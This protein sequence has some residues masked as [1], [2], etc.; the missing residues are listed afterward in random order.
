MLLALLACA[1]GFR[2]S[3]PPETIWDPEE[4]DQ[5]RLEVIEAYIES[6]NCDRALY[7]ISSVRDEGMKSPGLDL[8]QARALLCKG[9]PGDTLVLLD[10]RYERDPERNR[11]VCLAHMDMGDVA[12]AEEACAAAL[13]HTP[14]DARSDRRAELFNNHGFTLAAA[15]RHDDAVDAYEE[16]LALDPDFHRARNNYAFSLAAQGHDSLAFDQFLAAQSPLGGMAE[17]QANAW[18]NLGL[19]QQA[20]GDADG[21]RESFSNALTLVPDHVRAT[22]ALSSLE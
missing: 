6:G 18:L 20:R 7:G 21:A 4:K 12:L 9:L 8:L 11:L 3:P 14:R 13:K 1:G 16:A 2:S 15:G 17:A 22:D 10:N 5:V 19:A